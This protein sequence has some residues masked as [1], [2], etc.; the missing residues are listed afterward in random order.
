MA[1]QARHNGL[2]EAEKNRR[3]CELFLSTL[4]REKNKEKKTILVENHTHSLDTPLSLSL[5]AKV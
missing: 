5:A 1:V 2:K 3:A 4:E